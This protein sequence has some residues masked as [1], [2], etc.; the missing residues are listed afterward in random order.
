M[1]AELIDTL[2]ADGRTYECF[3]TR[4][5]VLEAPIAPHH[6]PGSY[7]GTCRDLTDAE[8]ERKRAERPPALRLRADVSTYKI[9]DEIHGPYEGAVDD[10]VLRRG[11]G[12][13]AYNFAVVVDDDAQGVDQVVRGD[14]LLASAPRQAYLA[15][16]LGKVPPTY[17]HIPLTLDGDG[18]RL[19][20]RDGAVTLAELRAAGVDV[21]DLIADSLGLV[22][23]TPAE[24]LAT[25]DPAAVPLEP[26][27][28][29][30]S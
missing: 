30:Q 25:F 27:V 15:T 28:F 7:P 23:S 12:L 13:P 14:D 2:V 8:R 11:D 21:F 4:R 3:C 10:F 9:H 5:E 18:R 19:A 6:P 24:L 16:L 20:K 29:R 26:W 1:Y 22:G 17:V